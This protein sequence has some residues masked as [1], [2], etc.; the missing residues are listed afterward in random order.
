MKM[1]SDKSKGNLY[2]FYCKKC[3]KKA[4]LGK[5]SIYCKF[6]LSLKNLLTILGFFSK[7]VSSTVVARNMQ[8][9]RGTIVK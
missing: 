3:Y 9:A 8:I 2:M 5:K 6:K 1:V 4:S 7:D